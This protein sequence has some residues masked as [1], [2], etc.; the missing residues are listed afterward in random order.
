[1]DFSRLDE[2][3]KPID[4]SVDDERIRV[5]FE[6][7]LELSV[8][9]ADYPRLQQAPPAAREKWRLI[10]LGQGIHWPDVDEDLSVRGLFQTHRQLPESPVEQLPALVSDLMK[11]T[12]RLNKLFPGKPFTPDGHLVGSIGEVV[13]EYIYDLV[14]EPCSTP[15]I[16]AKTTDGRTVQVKLTGR[17]GQAY[18]FRWPLQAGEACPQVLIALKLNEHGFEEIYN[19]HFPLELLESKGS[20]RNGQ[21]RLSISTLRSVGPQSPL[22]H[23]RSFSEI[24]RWF[25]PELAEVA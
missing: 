24:N 16:D 23:A 2:N 18:G 5:S 4:V 15:Q 1:M 20:Q 17:S 6:G 19:G 12:G 8:P 9:T 7:G 25:T 22:A 11:T 21:V 13:A 10:G 3:Q 14:L